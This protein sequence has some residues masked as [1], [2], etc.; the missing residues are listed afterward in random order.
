MSENNNDLKIKNNLIDYFRMKNFSS[1]QK[2]GEPKIWDLDQTLTIYKDNDC[3]MKIRAYK[4]LTDT[5]RGE[6]E[7]LCS[8]KNGT[9]RNVECNK[10][11]FYNWIYN[12]TLKDVDFL[13]ELLKEQRGKVELDNMQVLKNK[14]KIKLAL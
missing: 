1:R 8:F 14:N 4:G 2:N 6:M 12:L 3:I 5:N 13:Y 10:Y 7:L 9:Y 11:D